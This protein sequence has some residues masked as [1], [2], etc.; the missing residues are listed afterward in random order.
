MIRAEF[1]P[2]SE[3][4]RDIAPVDIITGTAAERAQIHRDEIIQAQ[5]KLGKFPTVIS[6]GQSGVNIAIASNSLQTGQPSGQSLPAET[7]R[8]IPDAREQ[9]RQRKLQERDDRRRANLSQHKDSFG[10]PLQTSRRH[11]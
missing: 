6:E 11:R 5:R 8:V 7:S 4:P 9:E 2:M 10:R 3:P 1:I